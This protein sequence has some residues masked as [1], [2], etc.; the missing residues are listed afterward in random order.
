MLDGSKSSDYKAIFSG[1]KPDLVKTFGEDKM[2]IQAYR[3]DPH[4]NHTIHL[5]GLDIIGIHN[6]YRKFISGEPLYRLL[7]DFFSDKLQQSCSSLVL[8]LLR[9]GCNYEIVDPICES[10]GIRGL[11]AITPYH[12]K[13][14]A[15]KLSQIKATEYGFSPLGY[16]W[17]TKED[18]LIDKRFGLSTE[19]KP[20][21]I[22]SGAQQNTFFVKAK[23]KEDKPEP[24]PRSSFCLIQ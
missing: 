12:V 17:Q 5:N 21:N 15:T 14:L 9:S 16:P 18:Q 10:L 1:I 7:G 4:P 6:S 19:R 13:S 8:Y 20:E 3:C 24:P 23:E 11:T 22:Y 2:K